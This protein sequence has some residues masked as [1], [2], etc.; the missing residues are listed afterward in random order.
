MVS[1]PK[2]IMVETWSRSSARVKPWPVS[3][4]R[5]ARSRSKR[6]RGASPVGLPHPLGDDGVH[7]PGPAGA[8]QPALHIP[9]VGIQ[10]G[11]SMS[12][13]WGRAERVDEID[14]HAAHLGAMAAHLDGEHGAARHLQG[15]ELHGGQKIDGPALR[16]AASRVSASRPTSTICWASIGMTRGDSAGA[17]VRRCSR[18]SSPSLRKSPGRRWGEGCGWWRATAGNWPHCSAAHARSPPAHSSAR[19]CGRR[20]SG[21]ACSCS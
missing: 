7:Q 20:R 16:P 14:D 15:Q 2:T 18:Q 10:A 1:C 6:S 8:E 5:A 11:S 12:R 19:A 9:E 3:G 13:R 4:S 21:S 17:M